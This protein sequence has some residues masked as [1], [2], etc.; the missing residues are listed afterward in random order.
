MLSRPGCKKRQV[1]HWPDV[2]TA[3][4][5]LIVSDVRSS[6]WSQVNCDGAEGGGNS[7]GGGLYRNDLQNS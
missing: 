2:R 3:A 5:Q 1:R 4:V 6:V 7:C